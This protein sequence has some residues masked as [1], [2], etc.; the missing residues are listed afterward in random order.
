MTLV[1][2]NILIDI[3]ARDEVW[4]RWSSRSL[5]SC[6][7]AGP[8]AINAVIYAELSIGFPT[9]SALEQAV[10]GAALARLALP[11]EAAFPAGRAYLE[12]RQRGGRRR[13]PLPD[14]LIGAHAEVAELPLLTRDVGRFRSYFPRVRLISPD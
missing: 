5:Y 3:W 1:D 9:E 4:F 11:C 2:S 14:F 6:L 7:R 8:V 13:S 10:D 12:Y